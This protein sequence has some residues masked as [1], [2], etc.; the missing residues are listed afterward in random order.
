MLVGVAIDPSASHDCLTK[1]GKWPILL[2]RSDIEEIGRVQRVGFSS[3]TTGEAGGEHVGLVSQS[4]A[5]FG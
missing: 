5:R 3:E 2:E 1:E 4:H